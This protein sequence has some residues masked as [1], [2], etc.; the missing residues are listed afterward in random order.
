MIIEHQRTYKKLFFITGLL[1]IL[2]GTTYYVFSTQTE[3]I[4]SYNPTKDR[5]FI[6]DLFKNNWY[7]LVSEQSVD[8]SAEYMLDNQASS[9]PPKYTN[10]LTIKVYRVNNKPV[11]F[12]AYY[13]VSFYKAT[14]LF[15]VV[16]EKQQTHGYGKKL[17]DYALNDLKQQGFFVVELITRTNNLKAQSLYKKFGFKEVW[18]NDGFVR[19]EKILT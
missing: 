1:S 9:H 18:R 4:Y 5:A 16:D 10:D 3:G 6:L 11:G 15:I 19:F 8:F 14:L 7:W 17:L 13:K 12:V 2:L